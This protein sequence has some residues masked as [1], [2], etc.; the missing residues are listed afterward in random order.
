MTTAETSLFKE[1]ALK[2]LNIQEQAWE[3]TCGVVRGSYNGGAC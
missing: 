2:D 1:K 3:E